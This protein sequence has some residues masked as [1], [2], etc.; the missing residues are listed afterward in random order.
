[1]KINRFGFAS[2]TYMEN[3]VDLNKKFRENLISI[4][5]GDF[6]RNN[7]EGDFFSDK[8]RGSRTLFGEIIRVEL[9]S[10]TI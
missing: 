6:F 7:L 2:V 10:R 4:F 8:F 1:M 5:R 3:I 9:F